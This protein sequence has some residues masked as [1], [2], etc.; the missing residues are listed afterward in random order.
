MNIFRAVSTMILVTA[1]PMG[2]NWFM[3]G[4]AGNSYEVST[5]RSMFFSMSNDATEVLTAATAQ[6]TIVQSVLSNSAKHC[7][8]QI[9]GKQLSPVLIELVAFVYWKIPDMPDIRNHVV[10]SAGDVDDYLIKLSRKA[11]SNFYKRLQ[12]NTNVHSHVKLASQ[13][14]DLANKSSEHAECTYA[15]A[16]A[17]LVKTGVIQSN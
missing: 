16:H 10:P 13:L 15:T 8:S 2:M 5:P 1:L 6:R 4:L 17:E 7:L 3:N 11:E 12:H 14:T 9:Q